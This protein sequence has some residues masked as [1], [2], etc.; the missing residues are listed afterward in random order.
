ML[1]CPRVHCK[2]QTKG[3]LSFKV[4]KYLL[5]LNRSNPNSLEIIVTLVTLVFLV[6]LVRLVTLVTIVNLVIVRGQ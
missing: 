3:N 1:H 2:I 4:I 5:G 6:T